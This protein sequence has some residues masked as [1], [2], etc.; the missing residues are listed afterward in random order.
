MKI[1]I[2]QASA[3]RPRGLDE[4]LAALDRAAKQAVAEQADILITPEMFLS[5]YNIGNEAVRNA[6][7]PVEGPMLQRVAELARA[8][9]LAILVGFPELGGKGAVYNSVA[10]FDHDGALLS[11]Y[12][13]THLFGAVDR[14]QFSAGA[15]LNTPFAYRGWQ[16]ALA[17]C[18]DI[19]FPEVARSY[20]QMGAELVLVPTANMKPFTAVAEQMVPVR[21]QENGLYVAYVNYVGR[22]GEFDYCGL[23]CI[24]GPQGEDLAR[25]E[26]EQE[27]LIFAS[28]SRQALTEARDAATYLQDVRRDLYFAGEN[29]LE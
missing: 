10:F 28:V 13:K 29:N 9:Q 5:G 8:H 4:R 11:C 15:A 7:E 2:M 23:S 12:Q 14:A 18:Y 24:C 20:A 26:L 19:E 25:A 21:A 1:C 16:I 6:A 17:I 22:E 3:E 27:T